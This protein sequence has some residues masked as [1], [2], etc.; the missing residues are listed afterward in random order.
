[1]IKQFQIQDANR[2]TLHNPTMH[3][4][5]RAVQLLLLPTILF[6][7]IV[8]WSLYWIGPNK[9]PTKP[10]KTPEHEKLTHYVL[11]PEERLV[12]Q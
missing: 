8:G 4:R 11:M 10:T 6:M 1:M 12:T 5:N 9:K 7:W 3:K 2:V